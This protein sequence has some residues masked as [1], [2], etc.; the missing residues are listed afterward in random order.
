MS[1][2]SAFAACI[3]LGVCSSRAV[4]APAVDPAFFQQVDGWTCAEGN[5]GEFSRDI[6]PP[7]GLPNG[8]GFKTIGWQ[9][10]NTHD[11]H[12]LNMK[13][14]P[15]S[16]IVTFRAADSSYAID[17]LVSQSGELL[18]TVYQVRGVRNVTIITDHRFD[19]RLQHEIA[20]WRAPERANSYKSCS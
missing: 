8:H 4:A 13:A 2:R 20:Y 7:L 5:A 3:L 10:D 18:A 6:W 9:D 19:T 17:W 15:H 1:F 16:L 11:T 12:L 14:D